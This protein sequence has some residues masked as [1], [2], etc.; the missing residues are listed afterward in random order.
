MPW[1]H[2][3]RNE[4]N[5]QFVQEHITTPSTLPTAVRMFKH[6]LHVVAVTKEESSRPDR[7]QTTGTAPFA[8]F[9]VWVA[10]DDWM[11]ICKRWFFLPEN[12][13]RLLLP[14]I[15]EGRV[16][17]LVDM[18]LQIRLQPIDIFFLHYKTHTQMYSSILVVGDNVKLRAIFQ[19]WCW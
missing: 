12:V 11:S 8:C 6:F 14:R 1:L 18:T 10:N 13:R 3:P 16:Q 4:G 9:F 7:R 2:S 15:K 5:S 19:T 17:T